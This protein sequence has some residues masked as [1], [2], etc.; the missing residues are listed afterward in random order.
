QDALTKGASDEEIERLTRDLKEALDRYLQALAQDMQNQQQ[1]DQTPIDP[2]KVLTQRDLQRMLDRA[3][4]LA[5]SGAQQQ[6]REMLSQLQDM[7]ENLRTARP[8][9]LRP[10]NGAGQAEQMM[11]GI[12]E[13]MQRQQ[14]LLDRSFRA[15]RRR[16]QAQQPGANSPEGQPGD[17][18]GDG[19]IGDSGNPADQQEALRHALGEMMRRMGD[20]LGEIPDPLGRAERAMRDAAGALQRG[21]PG[22]AIGPQSEALDQLQQGARDFAKQLRDNMAKGWGSPGLEESDTGPGDLPD[23]GDRD[24]FG[25]P[26][27]ASGPFDQGDVAIPDQ[28]VLQKSRQILDELRRRAGERSRPAIEL[29]YIER[30]LRRF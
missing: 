11:R 19:Q 13:L 25:R 1:D 27:S 24:P 10:G 14:Q 30:L 18:Q 23:K 9:Q 15:Q 6:A 12:H 28:A 22:E 29:D 16:G 8:G 21:A 26:L 7:L 3:R 4:E 5:K 2:S 17:D 20:G